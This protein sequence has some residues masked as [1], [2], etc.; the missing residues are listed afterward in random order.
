MLPECGGAVVEA[1]F[2]EMQFMFRPPTKAIAPKSLGNE[3][4]WV[5]AWH[6]GWQ[7]LLPNA[8]TEYLVGKF[9]QGFH[10]NASQAPWK[11]ERVTDSLVDLSWTGEL[12]NCN[13]QIRVAKSEVFITGTIENLDN[14]DREIII[15]EH[16][17]F[18]DEIFSK[19]VEI[20]V[21]QN[22]H[23]ADFGLDTTGEHAKKV[24]WGDESI[25]N[26]KSVT[27]MTPSRF[28]VFS[29]IGVSGVKL[30]ST[31]IDFQLTWDQGAFPY[32]W[33][34]EEM[35]TSKE[36]PW[37]GEYLALGIEPSTCPHGAGLGNKKSS[38]VI[39]TLGP[40]EVFTWWVKLKINQ[41]KEVHQ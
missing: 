3:A 30:I 40:N 20:Q 9:P 10:G 19:D 21:D 39:K 24:V 27:A 37:N 31:N 2:R 32:A 28:G 16:L 12:L 4:D 38:H 22:A 11:I 5:R 7:P 41:E 35:K 18:G 29:N 13:R 8:G 26:W 17:I 36:E 25:S 15:T 23:F 6:G 34:W 33:I 14:V 1:N